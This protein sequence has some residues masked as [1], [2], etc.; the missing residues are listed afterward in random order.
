[1]LEDFS[2][3]DLE[4]SINEQEELQVQTYN[5]KVEEASKRICNS[6]D[7]WDLAEV[8]ATL[9][10]DSQY[11]NKFKDMNEFAAW[12]GVSR[13]TVSIYCKAA[14]FSR[15]YD[16]VRKYSVNKTYSFSKLGDKFPAFINLLE[17]YGLNINLLS[18]RR[19]NG[20][21]K[22][23]LEGSLEEA[24]MS[25]IKKRHRRENK[26][27]S[28]EGVDSG[29]YIKTSAESNQDFH[30]GSIKKYNEKDSFTQDDYQQDFYENGSSNIQL[31]EYIDGIKRRRKRATIV[32]FILSVAAI[33]LF[34]ILLIRSLIGECDD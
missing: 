14:M 10:E 27:Y 8:C 12:A 28:V 4:K 29:S 16:I 23:Y 17:S 18:D 25:D 5:A 20:Y 22:E 7:P 30:S 3:D 15:E 9:M 21:V 6:K 11:S 26:Y 19:I 31:V 13:S 2:F 32:A 24:I 33:S 1:M 34:L